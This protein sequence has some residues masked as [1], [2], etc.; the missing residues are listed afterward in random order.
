MKFAGTKDIKYYVKEYFTANS[1]LF[2]GRTIIDIPAGTGVSSEHLRQL[3]ADV[4]AFD[5]FPELFK[6]ENMV[7]QQAD[8]SSALPINNGVSD[9]VLC[10]EGIEHLPDHLHLL[11]ECNRILKP[12]GRMFITTPN[13]SN[14]R[15][16]FSYLIGESEIFHKIMPA[17]ELDS[18]WFSEKDS[19]QIY[20][21]HI[22]LTGILK[23]RTLAKLAGFKL[24][25]IHQTR[26]N[27][28]SL[29]LL[30]FF[31]FPIWLFNFLGYKR[32][33]RKRK[34][35]PKAI[36]KEV[37]RELYKLSISACVLTDCHLFA[38]FEKEKEAD[39]IK[40]SLHSLHKEANFV[41]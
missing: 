6:V 24:K 33:M 25:A 35:I 2:K 34:D 9:Y 23:L 4:K 15:S 7:C 10:Q 16:R 41:T 32:A 8:L 18:I 27:Y 40:D 21:G 36:R 37:Y 38:E 17:N 1:H 20:Y 26:I 5:L 3:G 19:S 39:E 28:T 14:L 30:P 29:F 12:S 11:K 13:Y 22:F 31:Y